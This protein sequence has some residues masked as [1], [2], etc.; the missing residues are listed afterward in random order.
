MTVL[1]GVQAMPTI[2]YEIN[3][4]PEGFWVGY[5]APHYPQVVSQRNLLILQSRGVGNRRFSGAVLGDPQLTKR[6]IRW[7][8]DLSAELATSIPLACGG[9]AETRAAYRLRGNVAVDW[10]AVLAAHS[11]PTVARMGHESRGLCVQG[12]TE[13]DFTSQPGIVGLGRLNYERQHEM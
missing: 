3:I 4:S 13:L 5:N 11:E 10:R 6:L 7:V 9:L 1:T 2:H 12:T 8:E